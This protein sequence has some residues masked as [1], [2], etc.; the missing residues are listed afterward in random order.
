MAFGKWLEYALYGQLYIS[1]V[2]GLALVCTLDAKF[3][4]YD[5]TAVPL[6]DASHS[7]FGTFTFS[8]TFV[9]IHW[10]VFAGAFAF[11]TLTGLYLYAFFRKHWHGYHFI[12]ILLLNW[13]V[14]LVGFAL[15][16]ANLYGKDFC[17]SL[18]SQVK[19]TFCVMP[20]VVLATQ[21]VLW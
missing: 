21:I 14:I 7:Q 9:W 8:G 3:R 10:N 5:N 15:I 12:V 13:A 18:D 11:L 1:T 16:A 17:E 20:K 6:Y 2:V 4:P 19:W